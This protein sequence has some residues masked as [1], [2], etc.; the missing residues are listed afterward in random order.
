M[1]PTRPTSIISRQNLRPAKRGR[2]GPFFKKILWWLFNLFFL[3]SFFGL[4]G[5]AI[6]AYSITDQLKTRFE[7]KRWKVPS[8]VYSDSLTI[9]PGDSVSDIGLLERLERLHYRRVEDELTEQGEFR[10]SDDYFDIRLRD[11]RYPWETVKSYHLRIETR[12]GVVARLI[13]FTQAKDVPSAEIEPEL[14]ARFFGD[15]QED[16]DLVRY[17]EVSPYLKDAITAIEDQRFHSHFGFDP[18]GFTRAMLQNV[19]H[20]KFSQGGSTLTQ[21]LVKNFY[22]SSERTVTRKLKELA[23]AFVLEMI[24][25]KD[26][27][28][29]AYLNE[30]Y[31]AQEGT[32]SICGVGQASRYYFGRDVRELGLAESALLAGLI[33]SPYSYNPTT[34]IERA[35]KRRDYILT[36]MKDLRR[37]TA[38][39]ANEALAQDVRVLKRQPAKTI[40][41]Y[42]IDFLRKQLEKKYG[43]DILVGEGLKIFTTLDV[44][45]QKNAEK[46]VEAGIVE[47]EKSY[48]KL[49]EGQEPLQAAIVVIQP[50]TGFIRAMVGGRDY[51]Q[52]Q[53]N[54]AVQARR[55][56]GSV[57][58]PFVYATGF[59]R[60]YDDHSFNF[61]AAS[62][63]NDESFTVKTAGSPAWSPTN[64]SGKFEGT[65]TVRHAL[66]QS[67]NVPTA[68][69]AMD[70]GIDKIIQTAHKMGITSELPPFPSVSLGSAD[71]SVL[72]VV[73][74]Y[75]TLANNG[76]RAEPLAVRDI[77]DA[78]GKV[79]EKK[80]VEIEQVLPPQVSYLMTSLMQGVIDRGT[81]ARARSM[82]FTHP[83]A[84]KTGT[85]N[86]YKDAWFVGYTPKILAGVWVGF[87]GNRNVN[88][89][90]ARAALPIWVKFMLDQVSKSNPADFET[91]DKIVKKKIDAVTGKLAVY[92]CPTVIEESF[93]EGTEPTEECKVHK[94][95]ILEIFKTKSN[96]GGP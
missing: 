48:P 40:A 35:K 89:A 50:Q 76:T 12:N 53:F 25:D 92:D 65:V 60:N 34:K 80:P 67:M 30:V 70:I 51:A 39:Q 11:F 71:L 5:G 8:H 94:D 1:A 96:S 69:L 90:G 74:A 78:N 72:E 7:G 15:Q 88:L 26:A 81:A 28:F 31:F 66:E 29:E 3:A 91:P 61:T 45:A 79:L 55:Q 85:T 43:P 32:V 59:L 16:R 14:I 33:R 58:K 46:A 93:L 4:I 9:L 38:E 41:P 77:V 63:V 42:Y 36:R 64:Y 24:Y 82:G 73:S 56:V 23:M 47:L 2:I 87:D 13:D 18:I 44:H 21:Q 84:G 52:S 10:V 57:F 62:T 20:M 54:R 27:I 95:S 49:A 86:D 83:A 17:S 75:G 22:L 37:I 68:R 19:I 6:F